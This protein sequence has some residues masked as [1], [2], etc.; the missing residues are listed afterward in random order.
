MAKK[1]E[2]IFNQCLERLFKGESVEDCIKAY[3]EQASELE[4][5][6][7]TSFVLIQKSAA[8]QAT[9]QFKARLGSQL[10]EMLYAKREKAEKRIRIPIWHRKWAVAMTTI[11]VIVL[12]GI[13]TIHASANTLPGESLYSI[14][15]TAEQAR[16]TL[17]FSDTGKAK[18]HIQFAERRVS[19]IAQMARQGK[20]DEIPILTEQVVKHLDQVYV[21]EKAKQV[22][23]KG[24]APAPTPAPVPPSRAETYA[25]GKGAEELEL[26]IV[27]SQSRAKSLD[28]LRNALDR[29]PEK[30]KPALEQAIENTA[31]NYD[32]TIS[33]IESGSSPSPMSP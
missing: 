32:R 23:E 7:K 16:L 14:K 33:I 11:L 22:R 29:A 3:P 28:A 27:L 24:L 12:A 19:E 5:L 4:P 30:F 1:L 2:D 13:G 20:S 17:V 31:E 15:L 21:V 18:L 26:K 10:Q 25:A 8:I 9:P 6:L